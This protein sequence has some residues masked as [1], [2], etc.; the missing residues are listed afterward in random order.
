MRKKRNK[1]KESPL[2][3]KLKEEKEKLFKNGQVRHISKN[4]ENL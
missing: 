4:S 2:E 1:D 3:D